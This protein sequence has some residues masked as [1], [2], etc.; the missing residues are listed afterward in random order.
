M[1]APLTPKQKERKPRK[2]RTQAAPTSRLVGSKQAA[3]DLGIPYSSLRDL[4]H[5]GELQPVR[6]GR[7]LY[8]ERRDLEKWIASRKEQVA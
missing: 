4:A 2:N 6:V 8:F 7:L 3:A 5:K 1:D